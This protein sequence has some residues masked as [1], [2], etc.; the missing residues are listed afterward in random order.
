MGKAC[1]RAACVPS[2]KRLEDINGTLDAHES[3]TL[4][5][6][7]NKTVTDGSS[8]RRAAR[9][10]PAVPP[11]SINSVFEHVQHARARTSDYD[12]VV[13]FLS[14]R[15]V[16]REL[17]NRMEW[18]HGCRVQGESWAMAHVSLHFIDEK[19]LGMHR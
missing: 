7:I 17:G 9:Q 1:Q 5:R 6:S 14:R 8:L 3:A 10:Q 12:I 16:G 2:L 18:P 11:D 4:P 19:Q 15:I 13:D